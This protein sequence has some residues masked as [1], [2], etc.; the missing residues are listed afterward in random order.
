[1]DPV[2]AGLVIDG[3]ELAIKESPTFIADLEVL[4]SKGTPTLADIQAL[5]AKVV[6]ETYAGFVPKSDLPASET[7]N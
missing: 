1:M 2:T 7:S 6:S 5:R 3:I 4:F